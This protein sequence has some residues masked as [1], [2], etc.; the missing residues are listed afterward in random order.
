MQASGKIQA[1]EAAP[2][3]SPSHVRPDPLFLFSVSFVSFGDSAP[4][5]ASHLKSGAGAP[6]S[7]TL[8]RPPTRLPTFREV[9]EMT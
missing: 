2:Q 7:K 6:H 9:L 8:A 4:F 5:V 1:S 3:T